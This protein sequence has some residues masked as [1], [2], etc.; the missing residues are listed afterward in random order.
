MSKLFK[1]IKKGLKEALAQ[2]DGKITLKSK[3]N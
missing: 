1:G 3:L 2:V